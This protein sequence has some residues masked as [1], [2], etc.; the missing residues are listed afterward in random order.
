MPK[1]THTVKGFVA[2]TGGG[3]R[4]GPLAPVAEDPSWIALCEE[5][6]RRKTAALHMG[7]VPK[8]I[9]PPTPCVPQVAQ[10]RM[11]IGAPCCH[12]AISSTM[13]VKNMS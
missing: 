12:A 6:R 9:Q 4:D 7:A 2:T 8:Q 3:D 11:R 1:G 5:S 10:A 13:S